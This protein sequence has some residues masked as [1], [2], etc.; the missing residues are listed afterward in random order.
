MNDEDDDR[1]PLWQE[2]L[3][4]TI[5]IILTEGIM[6]LREHLHNK[7]KQKRKR[8]RKEVPVPRA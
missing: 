3:L 7:A 2:L 6:V 4:L 8:E 5:P 1:R